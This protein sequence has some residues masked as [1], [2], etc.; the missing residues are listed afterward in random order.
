MNKTIL[1][2]DDGVS[3]R[4]SVTKVF[5]HAGYEAVLAAGGLEAVA[6][7]DSNEIDLV[8]LDIG[9]P[10]IG[11][12]NQSAWKSAQHPAREYSEDPIIVITGQAGQFQ[13]GLAAGAAAWMEKPLEAH[14]PLHRIQLLLAKSKEPAP[15]RSHGIPCHI[16]E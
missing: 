6:R 11:L 2:V 5:G 16:A 7:F 12:P 9:L 8:L 1:E 13:Q 15:C 4:E 10:N 14:R 3:V